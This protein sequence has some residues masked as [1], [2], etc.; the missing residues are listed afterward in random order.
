MLYSYLYINLNR[1]YSRYINCKYCTFQHSEYFDTFLQY[2]VKIEPFIFQGQFFKVIKLKKIKYNKNIENV[3]DL[4]YDSI[5]KEFI[6]GGKFAATVKDLQATPLINNDEIL[7]LDLEHSELFLSEQGRNKIKKLVPNMRTGTQFAICVNKKPVLTGYF[8]SNY[9]SFIYTW[10]YIGYSHIKS[11]TNFEDK[12]FV[13]RQNQGSLKWSPILTD[14]KDNNEL[15]DAFR[16]TD[17]L[18]Q[19]SYFK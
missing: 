5:S 1:I 17:R 14:L 18:K 8:R 12:N 9:S 13:I 2:S 3:K 7:K 10:N 19:D 4:P 11:S 6:Y 16:R 15:V